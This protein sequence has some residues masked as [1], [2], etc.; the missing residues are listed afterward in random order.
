MS[1]KKN[2]SGKEKTYEEIGEKLKISPQQV[3]KI[4][5]EAYNKIIGNIMKKQNVDV[6]DAVL[7]FS[8]L[9]GSEPEQCYKKLNS[10]YKALL[11]EQKEKF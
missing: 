5:K 9:F 10:T 1:S 11:K 8:V 6:F 4:E 2:P 3:H 7:Y